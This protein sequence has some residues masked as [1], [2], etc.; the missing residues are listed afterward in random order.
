MES[1]LLMNFTLDFDSLIEGLL[2]ALILV[3]Q[4][5]TIA[6]FSSLLIEQNG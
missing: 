6:S 3:S 4:I 2:R 5:A 1:H